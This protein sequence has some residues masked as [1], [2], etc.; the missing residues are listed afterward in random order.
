MCMW[1]SGLQFGAATA[2]AECISA[3]GAEDC[4]GR[5]SSAAF[6]SRGLLQAA[7]PLS[8]RIPSAAVG[9]MADEPSSSSSSSHRVV[10][11]SALGGVTLAELD[12]VLAGKVQPTG[13]SP[14]GSPRHVDEIIRED[15]PSN[16]GQK[17]RPA[18]PERAAAA[19]AVP[20]RAAA[21]LGDLARHLEDRGALKEG[22]HAAGA[23]SGRAHAVRLPRW[24]SRK[25]AAER[26]GRE[27]DAEEAD[28]LHTPGQPLSF[29]DG[30][31][32]DDEPDWVLA[33]R[34]AGVGKGAGETLAQL[35]A[36]GADLR[37]E[38][39]GL[40]QRGQ[41]QHRRTPFSGDA[42]SLA[43]SARRAV[44]AVRGHHRRTES[45]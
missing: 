35:Q 44:E 37:H 25:A 34:W 6:C 32:C 9:G 41:Q 29:A 38:S 20:N 4:V 28:A 43:A 13:W 3:T 31:R 26:R 10:E 21:A 45:T 42:S 7:P 19:P 22:G 27:D 1:R 17:A 16:G 36:E 2:I 5:K 12:A 39:D 23:S 8:G 40:P 30:A 11:L 14:D 15:P 33:V 18:T 24:P